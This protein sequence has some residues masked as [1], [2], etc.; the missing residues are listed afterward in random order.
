MEKGLGWDQS[1]E[2]W[3]EK[4]RSFHRHARILLLKLIIS[5]SLNLADS[6][7]VKAFQLH[8]AHAMA[9]G[10]AYDRRELKMSP[11]VSTLSKRTY[12]LNYRTLDI[13]EKQKMLFNTF[14][15]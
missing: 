6:R 8:W 2:G 14:Q 12:A 15:T 9:C 1:R 3:N 5:W 13:M 10:Q 4:R 11:R 7:I